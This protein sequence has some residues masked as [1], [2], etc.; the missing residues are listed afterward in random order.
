MSAVRSGARAPTSRRRKSAP[1]GGGI[2]LVEDNRDIAMALQWLLSARGYAVEVA[3]H[4]AAA[5]ELARRGRPRFALLDLELPEMNGYE[6]ARRLR[7][8]LGSSAPKLVALSGY[9]QSEHVKRALDSGF[10]AYLLKPVD[11]E[12]LLETLE[13]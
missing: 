6:L 1:K 10:E 12:K 11:L 3:H 8:E 4:G 9:G 5:L 7:E 2:L 13:G